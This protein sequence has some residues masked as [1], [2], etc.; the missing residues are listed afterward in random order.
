MTYDDKD[1]VA[2]VKAD[3][4]WHRSLRIKH[5]EYQASVAETQKDARAAKFWQRVIEANK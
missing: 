1:F 4:W 5:A 3:R 2:F